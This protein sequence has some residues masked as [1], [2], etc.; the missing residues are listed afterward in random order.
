MSQSDLR[1]LYWLFKIVIIII[2]RVQ[3]QNTTNLSFGKCSTIKILKFEIQFCH[4]SNAE[5]KMSQPF[6]GL[7]QVDSTLNLST[8]EHT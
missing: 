7:M 3:A 8:C 1:D 5:K 6:V 2:L 4:N